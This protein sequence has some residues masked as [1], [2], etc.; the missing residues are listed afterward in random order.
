MSGE[1]VPYHLRQ[2]KHVERQLFAELL[3]HVDR[4]HPI[5]DYLYVSFGGVFFEDFKLMHSVFGMRHMLS[6]EILEWVYQRQDKNRP[7]GCVKCKN[8]T[9]A[10]FID[11]IDIIR[12][13][14]AGAKHIVCWLDYAAAR[15]TRRQLEEYKALLPKLERFDIVKITLNANPTTLGDYREELR[16]LKEDNNNPD[17]EAQ[18]LQKLR[19]GCL[20]E[21]LGD[22]LPEGIESEELTKSAYPGVLLRAIQLAAAS[23]MKEQPSLSFQ[24]LG[25]YVYSD[26][27]HTML[28]CTGI[29][30]DSSEEKRGRFLTATKLRKF[31][32][33]GLD[34]NLIKIDVPFLSAREKFLLDT[35]MYEKEPEAV[36]EQ[37]GF[38]FDKGAERSL[39]MLKEYFRFH[40]FYPHFHRIQY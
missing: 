38:R 40:R 32:F 11:S 13:E 4:A 16:K 6:L 27:E 24:P 37:L 18:S 21:R 12:E 1:K 25:S 23:A 39:A 29:L 5:R 31:E 20:R 34:W 33:S 26:S 2:N 9:S 28:T 3:A 15:E 36:A 10:N 35:D 7:Y 14:F 17:T 8:M 22:M 30:L 19:L